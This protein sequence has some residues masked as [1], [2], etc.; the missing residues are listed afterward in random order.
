[1]EA[2][3]KERWGVA[4]EEKRN[5]N[6]LFT[7]WEQRHQPFG[8]LLAGKIGNIQYQNL[9]MTWHDGI[10]HSCM[11]FPLHGGIILVVA[12]WRVKERSFS[13]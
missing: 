3:N 10:G 2:Y 8:T 13:L 11:T 1:M 6:I 7:L 5:K 12:L 4:R 9:W